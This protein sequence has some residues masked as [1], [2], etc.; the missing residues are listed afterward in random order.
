MVTIIYGEGYIEIDDK[1]IVRVIEGK[2][3]E[4]RN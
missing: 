2:T 3:R 1:D 4:K